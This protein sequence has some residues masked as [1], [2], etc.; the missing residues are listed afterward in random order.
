MLLLITATV[1]VAFHPAPSVPPPSRTTLVVFVTVDQMRADYLPRFTAQLTGGLGRL[2]RGGAWFTDGDLDY[3]NTETA[4]GHAT[5]LSG[6]FPRHTG[7]V[8]NERGVP[9]SATPL[10]GARGPGASPLRFQGESL[11]DWIRAAEPVARALSVSRKDRAAILPLGRARAAAFWYAEPDGPFTTSQY[12]MDTL[13]AWV[14]AFNARR[15]P[16]RFAGRAWRL[17]LPDSAYPEPDSVP[18]EGGGRDFVFPHV[19]AA[20]SARAAR[21]VIQYPWMDQITL[22]FALAGVQALGLGRG[23]A[24]DLLSVSLSSTDAIGHRYGPDSR[25]IHDQ[26]LRLDRALGAFI[27]SLY[28]LQDSARI[29]I[30]L[31]GDHGVA[32]FPELYAARTGRPADHVSLRGPIT[33]IRAGLAARGVPAAA[34]RIE[35]GAL[36]VDRS[37]LRAAGVDVDSLVSEFAELARRVPGVARVDR[38]A[39]L[40]K[41]DTV[42]DAIARRWYHALPPGRPIEAV[43][44]LEPHWVWGRAADAQHGGPYDYDTHVPVVFY[45]PPFRP[46]RYADPVRVVDMAPTIA[47][48][49][50]VTPTGRL[51]GHV[52]RAALKTAAA[53]DSR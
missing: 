21:D 15:L 40:A 16:Q 2:I 32:P 42:H 6:R 44:T 52:L 39:A 8:S 17:L 3:A 26:I 4:V 7:I 24:T 34:F 14:R 9:D 30:A 23:P 25:E 50:G 5:L 29:V 1:C 18:I 35:S 12:Y 46:G 36:W 20:D 31:T 51:D 27:D 13:P 38:V 19:L 11:I 22:D 33:T 37:L 48:A 45:G 49:I 47:A 41:A 53:S 43:V 28:R 10:V